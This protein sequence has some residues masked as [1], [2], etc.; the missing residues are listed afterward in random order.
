MD[1][2]RTNPKE[3]MM[4]AYNV[5]ITNV[6]PTSLAVKSKIGIFKP[7]KSANIGKPHMAFA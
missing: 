7:K 5:L 3:V 6:F 2:K 4:F 1:S